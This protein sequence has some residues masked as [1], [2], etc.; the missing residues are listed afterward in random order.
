MAIMLCFVRR[1]WL[2][3]LVFSADEG[4]GSLEVY[5]FIG[6]FSTLIKLDGIEAN[7]SVDKL[8]LNLLSD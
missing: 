5:Y 2:L 6:S 7:A 8:E 3:Y 1:D 4:M